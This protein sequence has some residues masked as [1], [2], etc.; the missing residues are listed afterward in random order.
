MTAVVVPSADAPVGPTRRSLPRRRIVASTS[1]AAV[2][3]MIILR[4]GAFTEAPTASV[5]VDVPAPTAAPMAPVTNTWEVLSPIPGGT[6]VI[7]GLGR[8]VIAFTPGALWPARILSDGTWR[9][10]EGLPLGLDPAPTPALVVGGGFAVIGMVGDGTHV[11]RYDPDGRFEAVRTVRGMTPGP[12]VAVHGDVVVFDATSTWGAVVG[13]DVTPFRAPGVVVGAVGGAEAIV[14]LD[15]DGELWTGTPGGDWAQIG[16]GWT[17]VVDGGAAVAVGGSAERG[18]AVVAGAHL[19]SFGPSPFGA[20]SGTG[21]L[22]LV[23][24]T[25]SDSLWG[26]TPGGRF[27][28]IPLWTRNGFDGSLLSVVDG[29]DVPVVWGLGSDG[30]ERLWRWND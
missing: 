3:L 14:V 15:R 13:E 16:S 28:R 10:V 4:L 11:A 9:G 19:E 26:A 27:E 2:L 8:R 12:A 7:A 24:D 18:L 25:S 30:V 20:T 21:E 5:A 17:S 1:A 22:V 29:A 23:H 6:G